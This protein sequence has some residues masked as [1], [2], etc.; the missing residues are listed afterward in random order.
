MKNQKI[1]KVTESRASHP[2]DDI[3]PTFEHFAFKIRW[4]FRILSRHNRE[5]ITNIE[6]FVR[7][8]APNKQ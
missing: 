6:R 1:G 3:K 4:S 2:R 8:N 5:E 7:P